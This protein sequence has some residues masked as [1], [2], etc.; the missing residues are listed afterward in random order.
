MTWYMAA[1][2]VESL[3][4]VRRFAMLEKGIDVTVSPWVLHPD[5][6]APYVPAMQAMIQSGI[7]DVDA[8]RRMGFTNTDALVLGRAIN[9]GNFKDGA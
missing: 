2:P 8:I 6:Q 3:F 7:A 4:G 5:N 1:Q 9:S